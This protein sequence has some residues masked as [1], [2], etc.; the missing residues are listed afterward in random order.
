M[1]L[2][3][4][5]VLPGYGHSTLSDLLPAVGAHLGVPGCQSDPLGLPAASRYV[6]LLV[7]G[8]GHHLLQACLRH[9]DYFAEVFGD[10][11]RLTSGVPST[12]ATSLTCLGTGLR[13][14]E[15]GMAGYSFLDPS[16]RHAMNALTWEGGPAD[17]VA[18]QPRDTMF[19]RA[20]AAGAAVASIAP[21]RFE[22]TGL[23]RAALRGPGFHGC[24]ES[25]HAE[26]IRQT[27]AASRR[28]ER[29]LVY[30]YERSLD[31]TGHGKGVASQAWLDTLASVDGFARQLREALDDDVCLLITG[32]HGMIDVP[33]ERQLLV[34][35]HPAL[36]RGVQLLAGEGR[37]RQ[38]WTEPGAQLAVARRWATELGERAVVLT[39]Q[40]AVEAGWFGPLD[41]A[42]E[43]RFGDVLVAMRQDWAVMSRALERELSLVGQHGSLTADEMVVPLLVDH[44][45][46]W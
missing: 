2:P 17:P 46:S 18:F 8:L 37:L 22:E 27:V 13:P 30:V 31:H 10:A 9:T 40:E 12:T 41:P 14:G 23:T 4:D 1:S 29:S 24:E 15:H 44:P 43:K 26:R 42:L 39:R 19:Q 7:D 38:L 35:D 34:E 5:F 32:D 36:L 33:T 16:G 25:D 21:V 20:A 28:A 6:L 45:A 3:P 11:V